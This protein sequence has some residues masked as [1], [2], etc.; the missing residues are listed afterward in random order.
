MGRFGKPADACEYGST[1]VMG[2]AQD[3]AMVCV[4]GAVTVWLVVLYAVFSSVLMFGA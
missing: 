2:W 3:H 1:G 4:V